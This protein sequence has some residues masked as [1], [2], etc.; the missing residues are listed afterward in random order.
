MGLVASHAC[1]QVQRDREE[2]VPKEEYRRESGDQ[3]LVFAQQFEE[4]CLTRQ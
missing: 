2:R 1:Q 3:F 4:Y